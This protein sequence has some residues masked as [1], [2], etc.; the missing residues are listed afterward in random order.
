M[1]VCINIFQTRCLP[2]HRRDYVVRCIGFS[3]MRV[4]RYN[5]FLIPTNISKKSCT[6]ALD[7]M[8]LSYKRYEGYS[9]YC[10]YSPC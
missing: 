10:N 4:Q 1:N 2:N 5:F 7:K 9:K 6:F 3:E 8:N